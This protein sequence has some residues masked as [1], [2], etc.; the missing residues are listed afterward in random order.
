[1]VG[2][3]PRELTRS[4][5]LRRTLDL[6]RTVIEEME[7]QVERIAAQVPL[8]RLAEP[9]DHAQAMLWL[10]SDAAAYINGVS[11]DVNGGMLI[12]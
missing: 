3:A 5:S 9:E 12:H 2:T 6:V 11:L 8:R 1:M 7:S 4:I 10:A